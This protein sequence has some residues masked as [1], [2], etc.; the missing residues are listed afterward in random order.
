MAFSVARR[1]LLQGDGTKRASSRI[2]VAFR[3]HNPLFNPPP[4]RDTMPKQAVARIAAGNREAMK[5]HWIAAA[6][7]ALAGLGG[8]QAQDY[9]T[10]TVTVIVP[11]A[12]GGP[13]D[14]MGRIAADILSRHLGQSFVIENVAGAGGTVGA[15]RAARAMPDTW[16]PM[17]WHRFSIPTWAMTRKRISSR[18][19]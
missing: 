17:R 10:R 5:G 18:S 3:P 11:F 19:T 8:A 7:F 16:A 1:G 6:L 13:A 4:F 14:V 15:T 2:G 9:P 12:A